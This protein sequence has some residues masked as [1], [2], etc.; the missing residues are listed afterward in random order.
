MTYKLAVYWAGRFIARL[1]MGDIAE[2]MTEKANFEAAGFVVF[3]R[4]VVCRRV[5]S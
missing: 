4:G 5:A 1:N 3:L 2:A